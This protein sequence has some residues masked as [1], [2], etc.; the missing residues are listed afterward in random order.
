MT[1]YCIICRAPA[2]HTAVEEIPRTTIT[3]NGTVFHQSTEHLSYYC[4][5][6]GLVT[7]EL[8]PR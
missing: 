2:T 4:V 5:A 3:R 7:V 8:V 1:R 6:H